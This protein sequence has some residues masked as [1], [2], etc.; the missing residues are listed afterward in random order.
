MDAVTLDI[1]FLF[2]A[3]RSGK[4]LSR[5]QLCLSLIARKTKAFPK[6]P[7]GC[8]PVYYWPELLL[9]LT[10]PPSLQGSLEKQA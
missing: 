2:K 4:E 7:R 5:R 3:V 9:I 10:Y 8:P 1:M 6:A